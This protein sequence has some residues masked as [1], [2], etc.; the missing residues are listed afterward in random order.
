MTNVNYCYECGARQEKNFT[1]HVMSCSLAKVPVVSKEQMV[2]TGH[3]CPD[4]QC[5]NRGHAPKVCCPPP[6][7]FKKAKGESLR[8]CWSDADIMRVL[9]DLYLVG[10]YHERDRKATSPTPPTD[11]QG[12]KSEVELAFADLTGRNERYDRVMDAACRTGM[13]CN[14]C[15]LMS[16]PL[17]TRACPHYNGGTC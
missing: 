1:M 7:C 4:S 8:G 13:C 15:G 3:P 2:P 10:M 9:R 14:H 5:P 16:F 6:L 12:L 17:H 11:S